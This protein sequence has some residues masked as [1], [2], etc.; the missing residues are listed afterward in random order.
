MGVVV[1]R[2]ILVRMS[3]T[4][5]VDLRMRVVA[6]SIRLF[7]AQG[8]ESTTVDQ[9]AEAAGVSR[10]T[11]FRQFRSKEDVIF[12]DH[13]ALL[14]SVAAQLADGVGDP[15]ESIC[16]AAES[17]FAHFRSAPDLAVARYRVVAEVP[18][19]RDRE[20]IATYRYQRAF[21]DHLRARLPGEHP[22]RL[23]AFAAAVTG[24][25]NY[26]LRTMLRGDE[27]A[28]AARLHTELALLRDALA[29]RATDGSGVA[30]DQGDR[31]V[32]VVTYPAGM[33]PDEVARQVADRL[34][35][36]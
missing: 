25:H 18:A 22:E 21:E 19:L 6:E 17:V 3:S 26:V 34:R 35:Q 7:A 36:R 14:D 11:L 28:T 16:A 27:S 8:Y 9:I 33:S 2:W 1:G 13:E 30:G 23:V 29:P 12:A 5:P 10:R 32:T 31:E 15:Y 20:L 24:L 4:E